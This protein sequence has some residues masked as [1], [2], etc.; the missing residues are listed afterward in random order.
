MLT[1]AERSERDGFELSVM[2]FP[3][4]AGFI[5]QRAIEQLAREES[6]DHVLTESEL[7]ACRAKDE[8]FNRG[9]RQYHTF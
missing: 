4:M 8:A 9:D 5:V 3:G 6:P 2:E 1:P 7:L